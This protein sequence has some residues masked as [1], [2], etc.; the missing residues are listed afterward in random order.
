MG[1]IG[2]AAAVAAVV[3]VCFAG[4]G[5]PGAAEAQTS[6]AV[7]KRA[8][9]N[10]YGACQRRAINGETCLRRWLACKKKCSARPAT[11]PATAPAA[12]R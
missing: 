4:V 9:Q 3:T 12:K 2:K 5:V 8:C 6:A 1:W 10:S 7:C 11:A